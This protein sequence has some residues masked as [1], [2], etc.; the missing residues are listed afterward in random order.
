MYGA[1]RSSVCMGPLED[2]YVLEVASMVLYSQGNPY[3]WRLS[4]MRIH[5]SMRPRE[6]PYVRGLEKSHTD[7]PS[8]G[9]GLLCQSHGLARAMGPSEG[10]CSH[11]PS[12]GTVKE[13]QLYH[14]ITKR[15]CI[16]N[17]VWGV[18]HECIAIAG[19]WQCYKP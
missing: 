6:V 15:P 7:T 11:G 3:S 5:V 8:P 13:S 10:P 17:Y 4:K 1:F 14:Q 18:G 9:H 19:L 12:M 2:L 16:W